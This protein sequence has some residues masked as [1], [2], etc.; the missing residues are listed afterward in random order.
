MAACHFFH[1]AWILAALPKNVNLYTCYGVKPLGQRFER[2][3]SLEKDSQIKEK[4]QEN[5]PKHS[6]SL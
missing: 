6:F 2:M 5:T 3:W 4:P 1:R